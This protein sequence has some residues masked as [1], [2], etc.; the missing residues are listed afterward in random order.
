MQVIHCQFCQNCCEGGLTKVKITIPV[1]SNLA[2]KTS[3]VSNMMTTMKTKW[4]LRR[5]HFRQLHINGY[6][7]LLLASSSTVSH[8]DNCRHHHDC[9]GHSYLHYVTCPLT[10]IVLKYP[11]APSLKLMTLLKLNGWKV[12]FLLELHMF[13]CHVG[14]GECIMYII[15]C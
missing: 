4:Q 9:F 12:D 7:S 3:C 1:M 11:H 2:S 15:L 14:F 10:E 5:W 8:Y 6:L 13:R